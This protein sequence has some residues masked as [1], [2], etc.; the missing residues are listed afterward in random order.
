MN[1]LDYPIFLFCGTVFP[2]EVL[3]VWTRPISYILTPTY[4][5]K[6]CRMCISGITD[7][8]EFYIYL[9]GLIIVTLV[10][11]I[12]YKW[13]YSIIDVKARKEATLEVF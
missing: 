9:L 6:L 2:I 11:F 3:P 7:F 4:V 5:L 10:Y 8:R 12:L 1:C 13:F